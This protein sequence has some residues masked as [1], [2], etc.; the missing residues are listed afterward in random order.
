MNYHTTMDE[1]KRKLKFI[2]LGESRVGKTELIQSYITREWLKK[3]L[4]KIEPTEGID[5]FVEEKNID[6][7]NTM[8]EFIDLEGDF[9]ERE[10]LD[11][12]LNIY[13]K[14]LSAFH[15]FMPFHGII[16]VFNTNQSY[17][18]EACKKWLKWFHLKIKNK[19]FERDC[20]LL[21]TEKKGTIYDNFLDIP[22]L[23]LGN[24]IDE[25]NNIIDYKIDKKIKSSQKFILS[26]FSF[27]NTKNLY[28]ILKKNSEKLNDIL[29]E[30]IFQVYQMSSTS[31]SQ[32][33]NYFNEENLVDY[34]QYTL[35]E[36]MYL[37]TFNFR[38]QKNFFQKLYLKL[39]Q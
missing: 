18:L 30:F 25:G 16:Y 36:F 21:K 19:I 27:K 11:I 13:F 37:K 12:F 7:D 15:K 9:E 5:I 22:I 17:S 24:T 14:E 4:I 8:I 32:N 38:K 3:D 31:R 29:D 33:T 34:S 35:K 6:G 39:T 1:E 20:R 2:V 23:F 26:N 10:K 28:F